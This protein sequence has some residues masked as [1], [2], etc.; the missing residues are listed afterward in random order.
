MKRNRYA[1]GEYMRIA[2][3]NDAGGVS[4]DW[5][6]AGVSLARDRNAMHP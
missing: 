2:F 3:R 1:A 6:N 5:T 4:L